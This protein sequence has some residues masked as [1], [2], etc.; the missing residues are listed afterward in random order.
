M[1]ILIVEINKNILYNLNGDNMAFYG[2]GDIVDINGKM[3]LF[4]DR[5]LIYDL[6]KG[7]LIDNYKYR[8][9][10]NYVYIP[11][12]EMPNVN[13]Q[14]IIINDCFMFNLF[15]T[16][17][18]ADLVKPLPVTSNNTIKLKFM[19]GSFLVKSKENIDISEIELCRLINV[20]NYFKI[21]DSIKNKDRL[22]FDFYYDENNNSY[23]HKI[24]YLNKNLKTLQLTNDNFIFNI[25]NPLIDILSNNES[26]NYILNDG[27]LNINGQNNF[28]INLY[29]F[30][31]EFIIYIIDKL[32]KNNLGKTI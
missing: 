12:K 4:L 24:K 26:I 11:L 5:N 20:Q 10:D 6:N 31:E 32:R 22:S 16:K 1:L 9:K 14:D 29:N 8:G 7:K 13:K 30:S 19:D 27:N 15:K 3:F 2:F 28:D 23:I 18:R 17:K 25:L 21:I